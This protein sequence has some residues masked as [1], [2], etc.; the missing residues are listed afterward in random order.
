MRIVNGW[1]A[2]MVQATLLYGPKN[3]F[4][5]LCILEMII[6]D[7]KIPT[8]AEIEDRLIEVDQFPV[9]QVLNG[10]GALGSSIYTIFIMRN[11][12]GVSWKNI[13]REMKM[14]SWKKYSQ[15][16][17]AAFLSPLALISLMGLIT[18]IVDPMVSEEKRFNLIEDEKQFAIFKKGIA[19]AGILGTVLA[20]VHAIASLVYYD[21]MIWRTKK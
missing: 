14:I 5:A 7:K 13:G 11:Y 17:L 12:D 4:R 16:Q 10:I 21:G 6:K 19:Q 2:V 1:K 9:T 18:R 3:V 20:C 15:V 8:Q